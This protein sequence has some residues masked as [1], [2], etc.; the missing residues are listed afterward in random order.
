MVVESA[1]FDF[2]DLTGKEN[3]LRKLVVPME[4]LR[5]Y[6]EFER[7]MNEKMERVN[8][9]HKADYDRCMFCWLELT[10]P[11]PVPSMR[12]LLGRFLLFSQA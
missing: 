12:N 1:S 5:E 8:Q 3:P 4:L 2:G 7:R 11:A 6:E 10:M 9:I